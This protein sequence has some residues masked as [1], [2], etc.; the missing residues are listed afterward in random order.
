[1]FIEN[2]IFY[3]GVLNCFDFLYNISF[4]EHLPVD[5]HNTWL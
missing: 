4:K 1:M 3:I 2:L 5:G